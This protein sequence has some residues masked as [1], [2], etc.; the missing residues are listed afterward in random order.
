MS[1]A[2]THALNHF[3]EGYIFTNIGNLDRD[4]FAF[5]AW[6]NDNGSAFDGG[7]LQPGIEREGWIAYEVPADVEL[8]DL[9][10]AWSKDTLEGQ[11]AARW[12]VF[13]PRR[14]SS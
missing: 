12:G 7:G 6:D 14:R 1:V 3:Y 4:A 9:E 5:A 2:V 13:Y 11:I 10:M 8:N